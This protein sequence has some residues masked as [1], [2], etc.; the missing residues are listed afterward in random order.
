MV[1]MLELTVNEIDIRN[2]RATIHNVGL[3][4]SLVAF[5]KYPVTFLRN[6]VKQYLRAKYQV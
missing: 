5:Y 3:L 2:S 1:S 4:Y 6:K